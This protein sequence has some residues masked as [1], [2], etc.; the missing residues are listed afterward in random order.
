[1]TGCDD[2]A[3]WAASGLEVV[4]VTIDVGGP[5]CDG[6]QFPLYRARIHWYLDFGRP[7]DPDPPR[8]GLTC[9]RVTDASA[10]SGWTIGQMFASDGDTASL[11]MKGFAQQVTV[12]GRVLRDDGRILFAIAP[13]A[14]A[15][16]PPMIVEA[17]AGAVVAVMSDKAWLEADALHWN[18]VRIATD[19]VLDGTRLSHDAPVD[20][21]FTVHRS[22]TGLVHRSWTS[23]AA[24]IATTDVALG[25]GTRARI[26]KDG[27]AIVV[28]SELLLL[29]YQGDTTIVRDRIALGAEP[30]EV[31]GESVHTIVH[32]D[33]ALV[34]YNNMTSQVTS[35]AVGAGVLLP[36]GLNGRASYFDGETFHSFDSNRL[37]FDVDATFTPRPEDL[38]AL[39][40]PVTVAGVVLGENGMLAAVDR[41]SAVPG[42]RFASYAELFGEGTL[43][44]VATDAHAY[45]IERA[46]GTATLYRAPYGHWCDL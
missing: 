17:N 16:D 21:L 32:T 1:M 24:G 6:V 39:G 2:P 29:G 18:H 7:P 26:T 42:P 3:L 45:V 19:P 43:R 38:A 28:D 9:W 41:S 5:P 33:G 13:H 20:L 37:A 10:A 34:T 44:I 46:D 31:D 4:D 36:T 35:L 27:R 12:E 14:L 22:A 40:R 25:S 11:Y 8:I 23:T 15:L 30:L